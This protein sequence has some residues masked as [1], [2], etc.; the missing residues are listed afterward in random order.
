M[1]SEIWR[2]RALQLGSNGWQ[3]AAAACSQ[4]SREPQPVSAHSLPLTVGGRPE[5]A[6]LASQVG[7]HWPAAQKQY[8]GSMSE[9]G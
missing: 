4:A 6:Q 1:R 2:E 5:L 8:E 7:I 9:R 3:A